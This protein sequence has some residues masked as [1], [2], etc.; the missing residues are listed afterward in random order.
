MRTI[1][2]PSEA[3]VAPI[4]SGRM[5][6]II[7]A[8]RSMV[9][10]LKLGG[11]ARRRFP[12]CVGFASASNGLMLSRGAAPPSGSATRSVARERGGSAAGPN[13]RRYVGSCNELGAAL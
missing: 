5:V 7:R 10:T 4:E 3:N 13:E 1:A 11:Y 6:V 8:K 9:G 2:A 12:T